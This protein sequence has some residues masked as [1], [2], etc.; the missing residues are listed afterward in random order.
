MNEKAEFA[1][2]L[3]EAMTRSGYP[4]RPVVLEREFNTRFWGRSITL[5]AARRWLRGEAIPAQDKLQVLADWLGI[6]PEVLRYGV[7]VRHSVQERRQRWEEGLHYVER[8]T[9]EAYLSLPAELRRTLREVIMTYARDH[10]H[11][12][13]VAGTLPKDSGS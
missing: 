10:A 6:E 2:R 12:S 13:V 9:I 8:E 4:L 3:R 5:Q 11:R 7:A 1:E